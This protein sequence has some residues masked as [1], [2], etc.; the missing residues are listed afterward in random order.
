[1]MSVMDLILS[2][3]PLAALFYLLVIGIFRLTGKRL[4]GQTTTFDL[5]ILISLSVALQQVTLKEGINA[6]L[7]FVGTV[8]ALHVLTAKICARSRTLRYLIRG[9]PRNLTQDGDVLWDALRAENL[10]LDELK[11]GLRKSGI[12]RIEDVQSAH[13]EETGQIS[14][15]P[16]KVQSHPSN[17]FQGAT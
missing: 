12:D 13:L 10:T 8:F 2:Q 16:R 6:A 17:A 14:A 1:M 11:A 9:K 5:I 7:I 3:V 4:A 15:I